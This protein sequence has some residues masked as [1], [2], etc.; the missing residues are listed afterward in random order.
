MALYSAI[1][2]RLKGP[3]TFIQVHMRPRQVGKSTLVGLVLAKL[4]TPNL[5]KCNYAFLFLAQASADL[6]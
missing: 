2:T 3:G 5:Y 4:N 1:I 6:N